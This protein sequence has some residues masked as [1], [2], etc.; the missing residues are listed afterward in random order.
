MLERRQMPI[1]T[2]P[3]SLLKFLDDQGLTLFIV[4]DERGVRTGA[5][6]GRRLEVAKTHGLGRLSRTETE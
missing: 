6:R 4:Q 2:T 1:E 5:G 3:E